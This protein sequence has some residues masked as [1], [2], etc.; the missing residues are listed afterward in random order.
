M[1]GQHRI[2][3]GEFVGYV[4]R[5]LEVFP[6]LAADVPEQSVGGGA[7]FQAQV[8]E[9]ETG[10]GLFALFLSVVVALQ[11]IELTLVLPDGVEFADQLVGLA[12][13]G[14]DLAFVAGDAVDGFEDQDRVGGDE[15][16]A[17]FRDDVR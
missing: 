8:A 17:G 7:F 11:R 10:V 2:E 13:G 1:L 4:G 12:L 6:D 3:A 5:I 16:T 15:G 9:A 14:F